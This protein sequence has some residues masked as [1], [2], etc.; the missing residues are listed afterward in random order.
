MDLLALLPGWAV[1]LLVALAWVAFGLGLVLVVRRLVPPHRLEP[2]ND[3]AGFVFS[4]IGVIYAVLLAFVVIGVWENFDEDR[5]AAEVEAAHILTVHRSAEL[6][7]PSG[8]TQ[9]AVRRYA[10]LVVS[11]DWPAM[12]AGRRLAASTDDALHAIAVTGMRVAEVRDGSS[13]GALFFNDLHDLRI[14]RVQREAA[15][16]DPLPLVLWLAIVL[17][18]LITVGYVAVYGIRDRVLHLIFTAAFAALVGLSIG[19][20]I[21]LD[22]AYGGDTGVTTDAYRR[23]IDLMG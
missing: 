16:A 5:R 19:V 2:H 1:V 3:V 22:A 10:E 20:V 9:A 23:A 12:Q 15:V 21:V 17:G 18:G 14:A 4:G 13:L 7:D 11:D 8:D 6:I